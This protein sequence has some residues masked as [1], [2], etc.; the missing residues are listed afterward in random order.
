MNRSRRAGECRP[1]DGPCS[2]IHEGRRL[3]HE[4]E[5]EANARSF[6]RLLTILALGFA[7]GL[8]GVVKRE[9]LAQFSGAVLHAGL[10]QDFSSV[11]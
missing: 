5:E 6:A 3:E 9:A 10:L 7:V 2:G 4:D 8:A 1:L 11:P